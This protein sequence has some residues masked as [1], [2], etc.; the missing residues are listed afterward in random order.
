MASL[1]T[2]ASSARGPGGTSPGTSTAIHDLAMMASPSVLGSLTIPGRPEHVCAARSFAEKALDEASPTTD[3]AV[4]LVSET[5]TN[6]VLHSN[7]RRRGGTVTITII[8]VGGGTRIEVTDAGSEVSAPVVKGHGCVSGGHG[9]FLVQ[10]L[11]D[12]WGYVRDD[13]GTTVW[14][15]LADGS[16]TGR[17]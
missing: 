7:S 3:A 17:P 13:A 1:A 11:A 2:R 4:L 12:Q 14:F 5:V 8:K 6:A 10:T 9:L 16:P 15:W